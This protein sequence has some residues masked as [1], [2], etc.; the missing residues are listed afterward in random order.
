MLGIL[1]GGII[2]GELAIMLFKFFIIALIIGLIVLVVSHAIDKFLDWVTESQVKTS[3]QTYEKLTQSA[4]ILNQT[5]VKIDARL[6]V[7]E[8]NVLL[9]PGTMLLL[10]Y[11]K[12][13]YEYYDPQTKE[14]MFTTTIGQ[15]T[16]D[17][18]LY[19]IGAYANSETIVVPTVYIDNNT[20]VDVTMNVDIVTGYSQFE[21]QYKDS[22]GKDKVL[23]VGREYPLLKVHFYI[24]V[25]HTNTTVTT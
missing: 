12:I 22:D 3:R 21:V 4:T 17:Y 23:N 24:L 7:L 6:S 11:V 18:S 16:F 13:K 8:A 20:K 9:Y 15:K 2:S 14:I 10:G 1:G 5:E 19:F 25:S